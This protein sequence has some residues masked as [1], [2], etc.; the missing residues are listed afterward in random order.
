MAGLQPLRRTVHYPFIARNFEIEE[1]G[2][3][4]LENVL[5]SGILLQTKLM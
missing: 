4:L 5:K 1:N 3:E 2:E